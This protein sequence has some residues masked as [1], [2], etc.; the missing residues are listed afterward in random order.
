[1]PGDVFD[2]AEQSL[3]TVPA[4]CILLSGDAIVNESMLTGESVPISKQPLSEQQVSSIQSTRTDLANHLAKHFLFSGTKIIRTRPAIGSL[5]PEDISAKAMVVRTGFHTT[6][7]SL[8]RGMLF[9]KPMGFKFYRDS[10]RFIG[11]LAAIAFVGLCFNTANFIQIGI[12]W[13]TLAIRV[14]DLVT[15]VV[16]PALPATMSIGTAFAIARLR[17]LGVFCISPTRVNMGGKVNVVCFDKTGTLTEDGLDV[18]GTVSY[19]HLTLPT[20]PYV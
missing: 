13:R 19:T 4:D 7:G 6:K 14:L 8:V 9:P 11:F 5:D 3:A 17:K 16:P 10:F 18:L 20:T 12:S 1:M 2:A 15:V